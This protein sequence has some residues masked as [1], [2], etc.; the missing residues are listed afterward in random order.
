MI[1]RSAFLVALLWLTVLTLA[2]DTS[3]LINEALDKLVKLQF[4]DN[5]VLP[6]AMKGI[7]DTTGVP[8]EADPAVWE[9][10]PW[11]EQTTIKATI[12]NQTLREA[13]AAITRTLGLT[14]EVRDESVQIQPM[15]ALRRLGRRS[16][17]DELSAL[18]LLASTP[19]ALKAEQPTVKQLVSAIDQQLMD[20]KSPYAIEFRAGDA[21]A[22]NTATIYVPRNSTMMDAL[23]AMAKDTSATWYPWGKSIVIVSKEDQVRNQL[24]KTLTLRYN[25]ADV[26]QVLMELSQ[27]SG[28]PF[29]IEPGA[30]Q[31]IPP[32]FR[33]VRL[34]LD[35]ASVQQAL[36]H[37]AGF[38]GLAY[39]VR[40]DGVHI[41]N[42]S[43]QGGATPA[44]DP[45]VGIIT[46]DNGMQIIVKESQVPEDMRQYLRMR[47]QRELDKIRQMM[48]EEGFNP[49]TQPTTAPADEDL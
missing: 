29:T 15:P 27:R 34:V 33:R 19:L 16:T 3:A 2:Q 13:L 22:A 48:D 40:D 47:T 42:Q 32:E 23:E 39:V 25:D 26:A 49:T 11:G 17:V 8:I 38:T 6:E 12:E 20:L 21:V 18:N 4:E 36:E 35:N 1:G 45:A 14:F 28:V 46:L 9:L 37:I 7:S 24:N 31:R 44:R 43:N 5:V 10:L 30:I 41:W